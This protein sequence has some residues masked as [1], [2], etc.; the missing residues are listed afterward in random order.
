[1]KNRMILPALTAITQWP[2]SPSVSYQKTFGSR[3][4]GYWRVVP[5]PGC[6]HT[7]SESTLVRCYDNALHLT[8]YR[9]GWGATMASSPN[10]AVLFQSITTLPE[11][12]VPNSSGYGAMGKCIQLT[13]SALTAYWYMGLDAVSSG[14]CW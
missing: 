13:R 7:S 5:A 8:R 9:Y 10:P 1:M 12:I 3:N 11:K 2:T 14:L 6:P 4:C